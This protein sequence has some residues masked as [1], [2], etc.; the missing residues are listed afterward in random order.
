GL[1]RDRQGALPPVV[2]LAL[3]DARLRG[4]ALAAADQAFAE[5]AAQEA[6]TPWDGWARLGRGWVAIRRGD[7]AQAR[8][9]LVQV[10]N[11]PE[12]SATLATFMLAMIDAVDGQPR[13]A[14]AR[15]A[16]I[17]D[18]ERSSSTLRAAARLGHAYASY[19]ARD[20]GG[21]RAAFDAIADEGGAFT[22]DARYAAARATL[23]SG[24]RDGAVL[25]LRA[26][27]GRSEVA[28]GSAAVPRALLDL[29]PAAILD[30]GFAAYRRAALR[31]PEQQLVALLDWDGRAFARALLRR[32][33]STAAV[34]RGAAPPRPSHDRAASHVGPGP[35][36][37]AL[38][39]ERGAR[40]RPATRADDAS[41][42]PWALLLVLALAATLPW[43]ARTDHRSGRRGG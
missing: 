43:L 30:R 5:V 42:V 40:D 36:D 26:L 27:A 8:A 21:A 13:A 2:L 39:P 24:D 6:G 16:T 9:H 14:G 1:E 15:F 33:E 31:A 11:A 22:D 35:A 34:T 23:R 18:D 32:L 4:G 20:D 41:G 17:R 3:A 12:A 38:E 29:E 10:A 25:M 7:L 28:A 19:W 37:G